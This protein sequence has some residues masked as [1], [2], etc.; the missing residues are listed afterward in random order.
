MSLKFG[1]DGV[2]G[3]A[4]E[5]LTT[6]FVHALGRAAARVLGTEV[7]YV[8]GRDTRESGHSLQRALTG[9]LAAEGASVVDLGVVPTAA[10]AH[11]GEARNAPGAMV[12]ASHNPFSDNGIKLF[13]A[14]GRKLS[15]A[16]QHQ[17]EDALALVLADGVAPSHLGEVAATVA[18]G[19]DPLEAYA[20]DLAASLE[21]RT[22]DGLHVVLDCAHG[23]AAV[24]APQVFRDARARV[25]VLNDQPDGR[26][27]NAE[28]GSTH[29]DG[30]R[31]AVVRA[32]AD[33]GLAFDGDAD[34]VLGVDAAGQLIDGD[35]ILAICALDMSDRGKLKDDT[36]V[37]T[38]M[39]NLGLRL[40]MESHGVRVIETQ[41]GD[42]Y[43]LE[44]LDEGNWSLA[45][46]QSG[47]ILFPDLAPT[48]DGLLTGLQ[49]LDVMSRSK[50]PLAELAAVMTRLPQV[51][52]NVKDV[53]RDSLADCVP[54]W[55]AVDEAEAAL[56]S[57]GR[58]LLRP[59]GTEPLI[60]VMV[61]APT[62]REA[63]RV[64]DG[65]AAVVRTHLG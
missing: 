11:A 2:R 38:V 41:V 15:D 23:S 7:A 24:I 13:A 62:E 18:E 61:E 51:L 44:A 30:L 50:R 4:N 28:C 65:L 14:G 39:A 52:H 10:V 37:V 46:E 16:V 48:G 25:T 45:G 35:Q 49:V 54:V 40:A 42:R 27:I 20:R 56:G 60:R 59:S 9:G 53:D 26:N 17:V 19:G 36:L 6:E 5:E 57:N 8:I 55:A 1:T 47:H 43:L 12:S 32:R 63:A 29:P 34:R 21:G 33:V 31:D 64:A 58:V 3:V 22:L